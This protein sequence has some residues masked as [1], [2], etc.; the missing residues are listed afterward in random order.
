MNPKAFYNILSL[1]EGFTTEFKCSGTPNLG[2]EICA[3]ANATRR[4]DPS[5]ADVRGGGGMERL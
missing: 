4:G 3:F 1:G 2:R 5:Q